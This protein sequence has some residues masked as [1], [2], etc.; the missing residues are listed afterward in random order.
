MANISTE[1]LHFS[2]P[3]YQGIHTCVYACK[4]IQQEWEN[5]TFKKNQSW[6]Q[7]CSDVINTAA[8]YQPLFSH[9]QKRKKNCGKGEGINIFIKMQVLGFRTYKVFT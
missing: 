6:L 8:I 7:Q 3:A 1:H 2:L 9:K 5:V 4:L